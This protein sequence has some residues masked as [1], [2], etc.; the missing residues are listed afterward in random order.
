MNRVSPRSSQPFPQTH[1]CSNRVGCG[2][3]DA[4]VLF[5]PEGNYDF[6]SCWGQPRAFGN[7]MLCKGSGEDRKHGNQAD[8]P[9]RYVVRRDLG[10]IVLLGVFSV[11]RT[12][13]KALFFPF[14]RQ[15][16]GWGFP[17]ECKHPVS[18]SRLSENWRLSSGFPQTCNYC[19]FL[20]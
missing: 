1:L 13:T 20:L 6:K 5:V 4:D 12:M 14:G 16:R 8:S 9:L 10:T 15:N 3:T 7:S 2:R 18:S 17:S 19:V 11:W